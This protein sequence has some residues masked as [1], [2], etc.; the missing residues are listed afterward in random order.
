MRR[1]TTMQ[2]G[3]SRGRFT[4]FDG[5]RP[6]YGSTAAISGAKHIVRSPTLG[7]ESEELGYSFL[8]NSQ[9]ADLLTEKGYN[10]LEDGVL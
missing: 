1:N 4:M 9:L 3:S 7:T 8:I 10:L 6:R 5:Q 2:S